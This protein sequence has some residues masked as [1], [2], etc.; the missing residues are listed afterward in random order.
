MTH[1]GTVIALSWLLSRMLMGTQGVA[2]AP[3]DYLQQLAAAE[4]KWAINKPAT[5]SFLLRCACN[6][7]DRPIPMPFQPPIAGAI[8][9]K[10]LTHTDP[11]WWTAKY[12][13]VEKQ[14]AFLRTAWNS[15]PLRVE[16]EY[17]KLFGHPI[18]V[19][20]D[21]SDAADDEFGFLA[22]HIRLVPSRRQSP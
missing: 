7:P 1:A 11:A 4:A 21:P 8:D 3:P 6:C 12:D 22:L 2:E 15:R 13:N 19:C 17:D 18:R 14:F 9:G 10:N 16:V 5:Y 20:V